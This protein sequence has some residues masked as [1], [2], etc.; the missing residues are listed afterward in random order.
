VRREADAADALLDRSRQQSPSRRFEIAPHNCFACGQL[1][2]NGLHLDLHAADDRCWTELALPRQFEGWEGIIHGGILSTILDEVMAWTLVDHDLWGVTARLSVDFRRPVLVD[3]PIR[4]E[5][6]V[7]SER[8]RLVATAADIRDAAS[9]D[10]LATAEGRYVSV[11]NDRK[12]ELRE[13]YQ[14]R[15]V[16]DADGGADR[17]DAP[18]T[19][20]KLAAATGMPRE[21]TR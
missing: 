15:L 19:G 18:E 7:V 20:A 14:V 9:G 12:R 2:V 6:W 4:A 10:V 16:D 11:G 17:V 3:V 13:R 1:N 21:R 5:G 8:R